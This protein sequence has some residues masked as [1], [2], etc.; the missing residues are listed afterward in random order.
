MALQG[1]ASSTRSACYNV[2]SN[3]GMGDGMAQLW[4]NATSTC[5]NLNHNFIH[6][7]ISHSLFL[8]TPPQVLLRLQDE[9]KN[10]QLQP[11]LGGDAYDFRGP[12]PSKGSGPRLFCGHVPKVCFLP[13]NYTIRLSKLRSAMIYTISMQN[14]HLQKWNYLVFLVLHVSPLPETPLGLAQQILISNNFPYFFN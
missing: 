12:P 9:L 6:A 3:N 14:I 8:S 1:N 2:L 11:G 7:S 4:R 10:L 13:L 5:P